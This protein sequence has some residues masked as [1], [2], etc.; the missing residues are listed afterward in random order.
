[1]GPKGAKAIAV[2]LTVSIEI[3]CTPLMQLPEMQSPLTNADV[4][5][6]T[7]LCYPTHTL[8]QRHFAMSRGVGLDLEGFA[9]LHTPQCNALFKGTPSPLIISMYCDLRGRIKENAEALHHVLHSSSREQSHIAR[10]CIMSLVL[11]L[12]MVSI[13]SL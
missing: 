7:N 2:A 11:H 9:V 4:F 3:Q 1:M 8:V 5:V 13:V 6:C 10:A 12:C